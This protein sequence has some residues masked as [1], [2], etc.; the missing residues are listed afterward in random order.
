MFDEAISL[1]IPYKSDH[2]YREKNWEWLKKRYSLLM[3]N[4]EIC[5]GTSLSEP[6]SRAVAINDAFK[7]SSRNLLVIADADVFLDIKLIKFAVAALDESP[8]IIPYD[9]INYLTLDGTIALLKEEPAANI[10]NTI[11]PKNIYKYSGYKIFGGFCV[12]RKACFEKVGGFDEAF[13]GWG[14]EDDAFQRKLDAVFGKHLR[15]HSTLWHLY[16]PSASR[17]YYNNNFL[18]LS[19]LYG[20]EEAILKNFA[21]KT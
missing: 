5:L 19:N 18:H 12:L 8:W 7:K 16:H 1:L 9:N 6:F 11:L 4:A 17:S 3:P 14:C 2:S 15:F 13:V 20:N 10:E 21:S